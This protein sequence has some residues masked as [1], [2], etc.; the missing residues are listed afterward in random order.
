MLYEVAI[1]LVEEPMKKV[2]YDRC[3][4]KSPALCGWQARA[5]APCGWFPTMLMI[6]STHMRMTETPTSDYSGTSYVSPPPISYS[7]LWG[8]DKVPWLLDDFQL[9]V[10]ASEVQ[11]QRWNQDPSY[12]G[13]ATRLSS[14]GRYAC[15][16]GARDNTSHWSQE[17]EC[18]FQLRGKSAATSHEKAK[19]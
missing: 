11:I 9:I 8:T 18:F 10:F 17:Y 12:G 7:V 14:T 3:G 19:I 2:I 16:Q 15:Q 1:L 4:R 5:S 13:S 6:R